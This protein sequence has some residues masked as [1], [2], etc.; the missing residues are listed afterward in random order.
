[1]LPY[2]IVY[3]I[4]GLDSVISF[5]FYSLI[6]YVCLFIYLWVLPVV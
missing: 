3:G 6:S 2:R 4:M 1:M 5:Q